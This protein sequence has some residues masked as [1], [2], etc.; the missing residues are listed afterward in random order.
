[1][2]GLSLWSSIATAG[3][4]ALF[5]DGL[6]V[7]VATLYAFSVFDHYINSANYPEMVGKG[8]FAEREE[9]KC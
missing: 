9:K 3:V 1:M 4:M 5:C 7:L 8:L 2:W 6:S